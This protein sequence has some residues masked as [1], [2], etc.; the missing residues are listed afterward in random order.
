M[1]TLSPI[2][3]ISL[4]IVSCISNQTK[5]GNLLKYEIISKQDKSYMNTS[6]MTC[7]VLLDVVSLPTDDEIVRTA[8]SIWE[9]GYKDWKEFSV[10]VFLPEINAETFGYAIVNFTD[11]GFSNFFKYENVLMGTKWAE[12]NIGASA[13]TEISEARQGL[14]EDNQTKL[15]EYSINISIVPAAEK[16]IK[17]KIEKANPIHPE[18]WLPLLLQPKEARLQGQ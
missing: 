3:L 1:K 12:N 17:V 8:K 6:R 11:K 15:K 5:E 10:S 18:L 4:I 14:I 13:Q 16:Q 9:S 7:N 2:F